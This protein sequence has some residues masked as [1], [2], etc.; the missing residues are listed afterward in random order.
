MWMFGLQ[1]FITGFFQKWPTIVVESVP[2][3][4]TVALVGWTCYTV[5][6]ETRIQLVQNN[7]DSAK[8]TPQQTGLVLQNPSGD[9]HVVA[10][11]DF[12]MLYEPTHQQLS[13]PLLAEQGFRPYRATTQVW[14][15]QLTADDVLA[16]FP[17]GRFISSTGAPVSVHSGQY[18]SMPFPQG[19]D[20]SV[21]DAEKFEN[22]YNEYLASTDE[23]SPDGR[24][25]SQA[26][27]L[28]VW[29]VTLRCEGSIY[30][31]STKVHAKRTTEEGTIDTLVNGK[32]EARRPYEKNDY[33]ICGSRG[34]HYP[35]SERQ[36]ASRYN[37][38]HTDPASD[39]VLA[40]AGFRLHTAK[41]KVRRCPFCMHLRH[42]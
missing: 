39:P 8:G 34:G 18:I 42:L 40:S 19:D 17:R 1:L 28:R 26:D 33:I 3:V 21:V 25:V 11:D 38:T 4:L 7:G 15:H 37:T 22:E 23:K 31:K 35:M 5:M 36:F 2:V 29:D 24:V 30:E 16:H 12:N 14:A 13:D 9:T 10:F 6:A 27:V 41:G 32:V 20:V